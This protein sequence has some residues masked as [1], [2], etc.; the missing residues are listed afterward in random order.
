MPTKT[1]AKG[2]RF[3]L[4]ALRRFRCHEEERFQK[5]LSDALR[6]V[7][8]VQLEIDENNSLREKTEL[9]FQ[10][11]QSIPTTGPQAAM[12]RLFLRQLSSQKAMLE[13]KL[14]AQQQ[15]LETTRVELLEAMKKR[16]AIDKI[17]EKEINT[18]IDEI[19]RKEEKF[20]DE[21]AINRF[22]LNRQ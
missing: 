6:Q 19:N 17:K 4:E 13:N 2:Y 15:R 10:Q 7:G 16:K 21:I 18:Y 11:C 8:L 3:K 1:T 22:I 5:A 14:H 9:E 12:Y 20:I